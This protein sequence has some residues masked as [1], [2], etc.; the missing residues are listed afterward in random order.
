MKIFFLSDLNNVHTK[1]WISA[2]SERGCTV[3]GFG[4]SKPTDSFYDNLKNVTIEYSDFQNVYGGSTLKK[5]GYLKVIRQL[6]KLSK[7]FNPDIVHAHYATSYGLLALLMKVR[8][9]LISVWGTDVYRFPNESWLS[10]AILKRNLRKADYLFST[11]HDMAKETAKYT[12]KEIGV[13]PFGVDMNTFKP[14]A[15]EKSD[16]TITIGII[17]TLE[18][19]YGINYLIDAFAILV[20]NH[21]KQIFELN[22]IGQGSQ[23]DALTEQI[24]RLGLEAQVHLLGRVP[25]DTVPAHFSKMD[26]V[27]IPSLEESFG[28]AAAEA[29]ACERPVI[30]SNIGGLP[31]IVIDGENGFLCVAKS[32]RSI[33]TKLEILVND[34]ALRERFG[35]AGR[36]FVQEKYDWENNADLMVEHYQRIMKEMGTR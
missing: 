9:C 8:P 24:T 21:P 3:L 33:L 34:K 17:K 7:T 16:D 12:N 28:V 29:L 26:I 14:V 6:K 20:S 2:L 22:I 27:V 32:A 30:A 35:K 36:K 23:K 13:V 11:S 15:V 10:K 1:K 4:L 19:C 5:V 31:E 25:H 18:L